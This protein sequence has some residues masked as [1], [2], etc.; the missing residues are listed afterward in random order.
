M[1]EELKQKD[2]FELELD[3]KLEILRSCQEQKG[4]KSCFEC[5]NLFECDTRKNYVDAVY[6]SMSKGDTGGFD[7]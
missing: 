2:K 3:A 7:F 4:L 1:A 5:E 6:N